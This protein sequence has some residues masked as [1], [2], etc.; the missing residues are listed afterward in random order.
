[1]SS[2]PTK[3]GLM[4]WVDETAAADGL[5]C[6]ETLLL[7]KFAAYADADMCSWAKIATLER[8]ARSS[9]RK[10]RLMLRDFEAA[11]Y[12]RR[13]GRTHTLEDSGRE[14]PIYAWDGYLDEV[15]GRVSRA[16]PTG[17]PCAP[18]TTL[19][20]TDDTATGAQGVPLYKNPLEPTSPDGEGARAREALFERLEAAYPKRG[21][22]FTNRG[23]ARSAFDGL[24][25]EGLD[26]E[27]LIRAAKGYAEDA[28]GKRG[29]QGL[30]Y[31]LVDRKYR[32]WWPEA[33]LPFDDAKPSEGGAA[34][35]GAAGWDD[36]QLWAKVNARLASAL[37]QSEYGSYIRPAFLGER[38]GLLFVVALTGIARDWMARSCW[39]RVAAWWS[40]TD[41]AK[42]PLTLVSKAEFEAALS[43]E[44]VN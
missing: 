3:E 44:G 23:R 19:G 32:G 31:W 10:V 29:D 12:I 26:L 5:D 40:E 37:T 16:L 9:E 1:M 13:T 43:R 14:V 42:R 21:L 20:G 41:P 4:R 38:S 15:K 36:Q 8:Q 39:R 30:D 35:A 11:G 7:T 17:A 28:K 22:G 25:D 27:K 18:E 34:H 24:A 33:Q 6:R 2:V